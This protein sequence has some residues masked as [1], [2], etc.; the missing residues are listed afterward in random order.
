M[1]VFNLMD[2][3]RDELALLVDEE[4]VGVLPV[5]AI[6]PHGPYLPLFDRLRHCPRAP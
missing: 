6:E 5:A 4:T 3:K 1:P 2:L